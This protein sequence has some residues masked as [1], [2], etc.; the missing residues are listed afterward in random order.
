MEEHVVK[1]KSKGRLVKEEERDFF[2]NTKR[3]KEQE[4]LL[5]LDET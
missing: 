3:K 5:G 1:G 4:M 2:C